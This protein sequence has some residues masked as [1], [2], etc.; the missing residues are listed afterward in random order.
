MNELQFLL[1][2]ASIALIVFGVVEGLQLWAIHKQ[3]KATRKSIDTL[4]K[5]T[6]AMEKR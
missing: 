3:F 6:A 2:M 4:V 5:M 1:I